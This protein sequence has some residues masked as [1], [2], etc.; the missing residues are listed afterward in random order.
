MLECNMV[1]GNCATT[2]KRAVRQMRDALA[3]RRA[4]SY[5]TSTKTNAEVHAMEAA[6]TAMIA[7]TATWL[8]LPGG[9]VPTPSTPAGRYAPELTHGMLRTLYTDDTRIAEDASLMRLELIGQHS[10]ECAPM[11]LDAS[12]SIQAENSLEKMLA[13]QL[14]ASHEAAMRLSAR[15][16]EC[17]AGEESRECAR[18]AA[19]AAKHMAAY[20]GGLASIARLWASQRSIPLLNID[21]RSVTL[22]L[23]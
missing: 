5:G 13:H 1:T 22:V 21:A 10:L 12:N 8:S 3:E 17:K 23:A 15:A 7:R 2:T 9:E 11:A 20:Q 4:R 14:A 19:A 18:Y 16:L 6:A